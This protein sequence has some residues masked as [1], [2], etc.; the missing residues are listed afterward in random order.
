[1]NNDFINVKA[2][3]KEDE[4]SNL[5]QER[6]K[7]VIELHQQQ[8]IVIK[9]AKHND[10]KGLGITPAMRNCLADIKDKRKK[11]QD[12]E[13]QI[14]KREKIVQKEYEDMEKMITKMEEGVW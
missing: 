10:T 3:L 8:Q 4:W 7:L 5:S 14:K 11:K 13:K 12:L 9:L 2:L 1:M 6:D